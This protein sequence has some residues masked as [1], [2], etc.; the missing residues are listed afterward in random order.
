MRS[1]EDFLADI[2]RLCRNAIGFLS[3]VS[4]QQFRGNEFVQAAAVCQLIFLG[5]A[6]KGLSSTF[7]EDSRQL[8]FGRA[9]AMRDVLV[10]KYYEINVDVV[11][12]TIAND[13]PRLLRDSE[14]QLRR[15]RRP[16]EPAQ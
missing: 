3:G 12:E 4:R 16:S 1:D 10:H 15:L 8:D 6:S 14:E 13:V 5:E 9:A 2:V 7:R 11:W